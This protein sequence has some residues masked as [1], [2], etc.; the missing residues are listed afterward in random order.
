MPSGEDAIRK[1]KNKSI[2]KKLRSES[3]KVSN[4][5]AAIIAQKKRRQS[6]KRRMCQGMCFSLPTLEDPFNDKYVNP[7]SKENDKT[8]SNKKDGPSKGD[9]NLTENGSDA[10][11]NKRKAND[12]SELNGKN[13]VHKKARV[14]I[15]SPLSD[16]DSTKKLNGSKNEGCPSK[17]LIS[18][19]KTIQEM[20]HHNE[21]F[22]P[23]K[24]LFFDTWGFEFWR[25]YSNGMHVLETSGGATM[26]QIAWI[27][28]SAVDTIT[29]KE[30][31]GVSFTTPYLLFLVPSQEKAMEVRSVCKPL[32]AFG[33]HTV[34]LHSGA[35]IDHQIHGLKTCEPEFLVCTPDRLS[36]LVS[37]EA[38]DISGV[39]S[40]IVD[41]LDISSG[42]A[43]L[44]SIKSIKRHISVDPHTVVFCS[45]LTDPHSP[46]VSSVIPSPMCRL[47]R[48][49]V[50]VKKSRD[51]TKSIDV[52][53]SS[54]KKLQKCIVV[55]AIR[56]LLVH[57]VDTM[58]GTS[59]LSINVPVRET[60]QVDYWICLSK[61]VGNM[62]LKM[63][64]LVSMLGLRDVTVMF[65]D[66]IYFENDWYTNTL[67]GSGVGSGS[68]QT[69]HGV[70]FEMETQEIVF[71][72]QD[73]IAY[74]FAHNTEQWSVREPLSFFFVR[75][76]VAHLVTF[77]F[78]CVVLPTTVLV[79]EVQVPIWGAIY[80]P[81]I[82]TLLNAVGTPRS[83]H[84]LV[85]WILFE[86][87]MSLHRTKGTFIGLFEAG[88]RVNEW[89]VT[90]KL[91]EAL[92]SKAGSKATKKP[93]IK[94]WERYGFNA[95]S[96]EDHGFKVEPLGGCDIGDGSQVFQTQYLIAY[97]FAHNREQWSV[98]ESL[99]D[100]VA[101]EII[102]KCM[103]G[104]KENM[105]TWLDM[106]MLNNSLRR[107]SD[108]MGL[109]CE[110]N[111]EIWVAKGLLD[112]VNEIILDIVG[113]HFTLSLN[114]VLSE[115]R[116]EEK[117]SKGHVY[118][119][120]KVKIIKWSAQELT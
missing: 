86:N 55:H 87:V 50:T 82:V 72:T 17:F 115:N 70:K 20:M 36:E 35:S 71:Q 39:C 29:R 28:S 73:I 1:K 100:A 75:K 51:I 79:P 33:I 84:L 14:E 69:L 88:T 56:V 58:A 89:V 3:N 63:K 44:D 46:A 23:G 62:L 102:S 8:K 97:Q 106:Y 111:A 91:G 38:V 103:V 117:K 47:S 65:G 76:I 113:G 98:R 64:I 49:E 45:G 110:S 85:F 27:A 24:P 120:L 12:K 16:K 107:S 54:K 99:R 118:M 80:I 43:Y 32:K 57:L 114:G 13:Q 90:K 53:T 109:I 108:Y 5:V 52:V 34:S 67:K 41:G 61:G 60:Q 11:R 92:K 7:D 95:E 77:I 40:L 15:G 19:L 4:R 26:E 6:G 81:S 30:K 96:Q 9:D 74:Q 78:Y 94:I 21:A 68:T 83:F 66:M 48:D 93:R 2:R 31:E 101:C 10:P 25:C 22:E 37:M 59:S 116:D 42:D 119:Q 112:E 104:M 105:D 18:C